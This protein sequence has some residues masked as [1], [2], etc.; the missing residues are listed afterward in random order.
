[1]NVKQSGQLFFKWSGMTPCNIIME[2]MELNQVS[3]LLAGGL[4]QD[5]NLAPQLNPGISL[6]S[7]EV[8]RVNNSW[9]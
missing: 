9:G 7:E 8:W 2:E 3:N 4:F 6:V 1:M 5:K